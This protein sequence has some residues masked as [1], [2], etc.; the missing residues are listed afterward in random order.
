M[1]CFVLC[2]FYKFGLSSIDYHIWYYGT[3]DH[4][5]S[6]FLYFLY[7]C[8]FLWCRFGRIISLHYLYL[9]NVFISLWFFYDN[10]LSLHLCIYL[11]NCV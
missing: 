4:S 6:W 11:W 5:C 2:N 7:W 8:W 10:R 3:C 1:C 9:S